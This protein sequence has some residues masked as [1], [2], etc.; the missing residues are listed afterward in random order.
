MLNAETGDRQCTSDDCSLAP[1]IPGFNFL[2]IV[3]IYL[4]ISVNLTVWISNIQTGFLMYSFKKLFIVINE[5]K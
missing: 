3:S 5:M 2:P 4:A 1:L